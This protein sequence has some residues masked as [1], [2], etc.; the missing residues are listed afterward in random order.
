MRVGKSPEHLVLS[1]D[2]AALYVN[3]VNDGTVSVVSLETGKVTRT[4]AVGNSPHGI[5][6]SEDGRT[7]FV[8]DRGNDQLH[9]I[10]LGSSSK[11]SVSLSP[12]PYHL[13]VVRGEGKLYVSSTEKPIIWV[14]DQITLQVTGEIPIGGKGHQMV[15]LPRR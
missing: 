1:P 10:D 4:F 9:A 8:S 5:D 7:L 11:I 13:A 3:N 12:S 14:V 15:V 6:L 2:G